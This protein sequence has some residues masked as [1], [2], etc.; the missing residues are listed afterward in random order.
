[1]ALSGFWLGGFGN[2]QLMLIYLFGMLYYALHYPAKFAFIQQIFDRSQY[3]SLTGLL[4]IQGQAAMMIAGGLGGILV[5]HVSLTTILLFDAATY[6]VSFLIQSTIPYEATH[7]RPTDAGT[8]R[9]SV[10]RQYRRWLALA[11]RAAAARTLLCLHPR[12]VSRGD[13]R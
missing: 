2:T 10:W 3:Q 6:L 5:E 13:G 7:L 1:M 12:A 11:A 4:E 8:A 9:P